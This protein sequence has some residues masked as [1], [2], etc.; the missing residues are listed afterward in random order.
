MGLRVTERQSTHV[1]FDS[2]PTEINSG[3]DTTGLN[4][5]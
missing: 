4:L 3:I 2:A 5:T 1:G